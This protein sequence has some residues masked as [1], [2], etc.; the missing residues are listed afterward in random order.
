MSPLEKMPVS[1]NAAFFVDNEVI[2]LTRQGV[3]VAD[4]TEISHEPT[5]K[6]FA[7]S[8]K[9]DE[10]GYYLHI[11]CETKR[12]EVEDTAYFVHRIDG[13]PGQGVEL[14][15]NDETRERLKPGTLAYRPGR[16]TARIRNG[17]EEAKFLHSPYFDLLKHLE[18]DARGYYLTFRDGGRVEL[19][20][21]K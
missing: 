7:R 5:R 12:I 17:E 11:G 6:L 10:E 2:V 18:E 14:W 3:W 8:L 9:R 15:I 21:R 4:G 20:G 16:L 1:P 13:D 19:A